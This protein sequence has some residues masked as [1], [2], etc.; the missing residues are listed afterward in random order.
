MVF[1]H[2]QFDLLSEIL[3]ARDGPFMYQKSTR[4]PGWESGSKKRWAKG[5]TR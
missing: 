4:E 5:E 3:E 2:C 1:T